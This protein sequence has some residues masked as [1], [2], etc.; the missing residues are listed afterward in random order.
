M[1]WKGEKYAVRYDNENAN[2]FNMQS[3]ADRKSVTVSLLHNPNQKVSGK[4]AEKKTTDQ[5]KVSDGR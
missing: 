1:Q 2:M 5:S 4:K 3:K